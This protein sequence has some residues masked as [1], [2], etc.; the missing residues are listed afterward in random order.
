MHASYFVSGSDDRYAKRDASGWQP[1]TALAGVDAFAIDNN[2][3]R[4][5]INTPAPDFYPA[6]NIFLENGQILGQTLADTRI[7]STVFLDFDSNNRPHIGYVDTAA[8][9]LKHSYWSGTGWTT[10][11][12]ASGPEFQ[13][14]NSSFVATLDNADQIHFSW[15]DGADSLRYAKPTGGT[16][17]LSTPFPG[18]NARPQDIVTDAE[19]NVHLAYDV[20]TGNVFTGGLFYGLLEGTIWDGGRVEGLDSFGP[21]RTKIVVDNQHQPHLFTYDS[22]F[23]GPDELKHVYLENNAWTNEVLDTI[24][25]STSGPDEIEALVD[26]NGL[27]VLYS[28]GNKTIHYAHLE[29]PLGVDQ[30]GDGDVDGADFLAIQR[31]DPALIPQWVAAYGNNNAPLAPPITQVPEPSGAMLLLLSIAACQRRSLS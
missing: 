7:S 22:I 10:S 15:E 20:F 16:W 18:T 23:L 28:T 3:N 11:S 17:Q 2:D 5:F 6:Y 26:A 30:D 9:Q 21:G 4:F 13:F 31:N 12:V 25:S 19:G 8:Q 27:H 14:G 24:T 29:L 1:A